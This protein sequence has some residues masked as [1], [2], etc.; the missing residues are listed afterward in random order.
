MNFELKEYQIRKH[1]LGQLEAEKDNI[2]QSIEK[3]YSQQMRHEAGALETLAEMIAAFDRIIAAGDWDSSL[4]LRNTLKPLQAM[5]EEALR[6]QAELSGNI[7]VETIAAP[8]LAP[9]MVKVYI[10]IFQHKAHSFKDWEVQLRSLQQYILGR[11]VYQDERAAQQNI[12]AKL[13]QTSDAYVG[14]A[15]SKTAIQTEAFKSAQTDKHGNTLLQLVPGAVKTENILEFIYQDKR[16]YFNEG[17]LTE[18]TKI[19]E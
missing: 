9:D 4:F 2:V 10:S 12:R 19:G 18:Q 16:Y 8:V 11:P 13:V 3:F 15:V 14:V 1:L 5:R 17:R 7:K 6:L